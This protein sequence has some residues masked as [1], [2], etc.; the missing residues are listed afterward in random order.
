MADDNRA[1]E[2]NTNEENQNPNGNSGQQGNQKKRT[3]LGFSYKSVGLVILAI[4]II[5]GG[6]YGI[7]EYE[8]YQNHVNTN[9]AK[10]DGHI[11]PVLS[12]V[13][14]YVDSV[15]VQDNEPVKKGQM[16]VQIDTTEYKLKVRMARAA[17]QDT[18]ASLEVA[19]ADVQAARVNLNQAQTDYHRVKNLYQG[20]AATKSKYQNVKTELASAKTKLTKAKR[21]VAVLQNQIK[22]K[23]DNLENAKLQLSYT[24]IRAGSKGVISKKD[25]KAGQYITPGEPLMSLTDV[26]DVW[27]TAN[28][29]ETGLHDIRV[30]QKAKI[31][32]DAYPHKKFI[33]RVQSIAGATAAKFSLL[34]PNNATGNYVK[35]VQRVPV[36][37]VF[38]QKP[39]PNYPIRLG[40][41][42]EV[43][44]NINQHVK[45]KHS[46]ATLNQ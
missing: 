46:R 36:K 4:A 1:S 35:V 10:T 2:G 44:I 24:S 27:V 8:Y 11:N 12:R 3:L 9:D 43:S 40:L 5:I 20:G 28:F 19:K 37:I 38:T 26:Q 32:I 30:G 42:V 25:I 29:K 15:Y 45:N 39:N 14:G 31:S 7:T 21:H 13:S 16:L 33:G 17:L 22:S 34:P 23:K 6:Y 18:R 41:N